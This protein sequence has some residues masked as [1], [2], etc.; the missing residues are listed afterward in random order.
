[1]ASV[2]QQL[3][4]TSGRKAAILARILQLR[5]EQWELDDSQVGIAYMLSCYGMRALNP[6]R[7]SKA[8][9]PLQAQAEQLRGRLQAQIQVLHQSMDELGK[10]SK[11]VTNIQAGKLS[12]LAERD[13][14]RLR[15]EMKANSYVEEL[16]SL[17]AKLKKV[18]LTEE[19]RQC[20]KL[21]PMCSSRK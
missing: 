4:L 18:G 6:S 17:Q 21:L 15:S 20:D 13:Q 11:A 8:K 14:R 16:A 2:V 10:V 12:E 1:M 9:L 7:Y 3:G 5:S 19:V